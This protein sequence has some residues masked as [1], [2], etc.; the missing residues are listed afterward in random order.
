MTLVNALESLKEKGIK[1]MVGFGPEADIDRYIQN[2]K[3]CSQQARLFACIAIISW[4]SIPI[5][6]ATID[7]RSRHS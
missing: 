6:V 7:A 1:R 4:R 2:A 5:I 3:D